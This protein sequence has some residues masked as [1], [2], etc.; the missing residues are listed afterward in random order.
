MAE[1]FK[2]EAVCGL[3]LDDVLAQYIAGEEAGNPPDRKDLLAR[4]PQFADDLREFFAN[5]DQ[6]QRLAQPLRGSGDAN[7]A[8]RRPLGKVR[9]FGD[10]EL[11]EE[12]AI[13]G[14]GIVYKARQPSLN[15]IVAVKM[16]LKGTQKRT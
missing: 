2:V 4:Y 14:M 5:R 3:S 16:I 6:M 7:R 15:R 10:Y 8:S 12:I 9:Y 1:D 11:L 13:G